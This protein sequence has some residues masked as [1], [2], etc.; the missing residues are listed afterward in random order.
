MNLNFEKARNLMVENQLRPNKVS[1]KAILNLFNT[2]KKEN[3]IPENFLSICYADKDLDILPSRGYLKNL[4][5]AQILTYAKIN[6][7]HKVLHIGG[8]TGYFSVMISKLCK[9]IYVIENEDQSLIKLEENIKNKDLNN[10][11]L[12]K[13]EFNEGFINQSPYDIIIIDCPVYDLNKK[14]IDQLSTN[15]GKLIYIKKINSHL[16]KAFGIIKNNESILNEF[17][18]DVFSNYSMDTKNEDFKF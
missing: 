14:I 18:F 8:L 7:N 2:I 10:I 11:H 12:I 16:S 17:L 4:H 5:L 13:K 3:F 6:K 9:D 15:N 1:E